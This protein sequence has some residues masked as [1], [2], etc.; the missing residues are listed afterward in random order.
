[1]ADLFMKVTGIEGESEAEGHKK[2]IELLSWGFKAEN[3]GSF[4]HGGGGGTG[5]V[6]LHNFDIT[7]QMD[8]ASANLFLFCANGKHIDKV[9]FTA[10]KSG[11][12]T[13]PEDFLII[14]MEHCVI[15]HYST[16]GGEGGDVPTE[17]IKLNYAKI[18]IEYKQQQANGTLA[19]KG[20]A[21]YDL[22]GSAA[23]AG[24]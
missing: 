5:K 15:A 24:K 20:T 19:V 9:V 23:K 8:A 22:R 1:M 13:T 11:G 21:S 10:R 12:G 14:T 18:A 7:K 2:E 3:P 16:G 4:Q 6:T 17:D